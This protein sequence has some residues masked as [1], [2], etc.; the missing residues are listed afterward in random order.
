MD[1]ARIQ[2]RAVAKIAIIALAMAAC[3]L[4]LALIVIHTRTTLQW[5]IISVFFA[6]GLAPVVGLVERLKIR[7]HG[8]PRWLAI[9]IV[10]IVGFLFFLFVLL[11]V[12]PP[13]VKEV[14]KLGD[15]AADL[16][17]R[18][19][20]L[21]REERGV[22]RAQRQ[23]RH[24]PDADERG[25]AAPLEARRRGLR[26]RRADGHGREQR[27]RRDH[28]PGALVLPPP[29]PRQAVPEAAQLPAT[30]PTRARRIG[31]GVFRSSSPTSP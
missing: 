4:V 22:P 29:R 5:V 18:L 28:D 17:L 30:P 19:R 12:I 8:L 11:Q 16:H 25:Q 21:G 1:A 3:A 15:S 2:A 10:Y 14:E 20:G 23:V 26:G 9:L 6:L 27:L 13:M 24:H 7:G 31:E